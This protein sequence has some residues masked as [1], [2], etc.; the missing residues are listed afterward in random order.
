MRIVRDELRKKFLVA[1]EN[2]GS[3]TIR[4]E[5]I[6]SLLLLLVEI[7]AQT[8]AEALR[9]R[10]KRNLLSTLFLQGPLL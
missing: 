1:L 6:E 5:D 9:L 2:C 7:Q 8:A 3:N 4:D 10:I